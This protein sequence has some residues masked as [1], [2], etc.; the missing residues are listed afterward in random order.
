MSG[1]PTSAYEG[2]VLA[3][4]AREPCSHCSAPAEEQASAD[5]VATPPSTPLADLLSRAV[6]A[7]RM[8]R[9]M[10]GVEI[11]RAPADSGAVAAPVAG[12]AAQ[13]ATPAG[14]DAGAAAGAGGCALTTFTGSN[15]GGQTVVA[16]TEFVGALERINQ[17]AA[18]NAVD[19]HVTHSFRTTTVVPGAIVTPAARSNHLAGHAIDM[20]VKHGPNKRSFCNSTCLSGASLPAGV[21]GFIAAIQSDPGL[22]WGGDFG[23]RDPVHIDDNLNADDAAWTA[24]R[25]A[26]QAARNSGCG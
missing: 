25:N 3:R 16:D 9:V 7:R 22:R 17:H 12:T 24:R 8:T 13:A 26:V 19:L 15:F 4:C 2:A 23:E 5:S 20:N 6:A 10:A 11:Q 18:N 1:T 14:A 21:S